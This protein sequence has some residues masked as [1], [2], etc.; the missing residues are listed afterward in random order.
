M[1]FAA[2]STKI[3]TTVSSAVVWRL[4]KPLSKSF[5]IETILEANEKL[6]EMVESKSS[7][8]ASDASGQRSPVKVSE[9]ICHL[10]Q[11]IVTE[12]K[13]AM[14]EAIRS[15]ASGRRASCSVRA[16]SPAGDP[17]SQLGDLSN[18][19]TKEICDKILALYHFLKLHRSGGETTSVMSLKSLLQFQ[20][21]MKGLEKVVSVSRSSSWFTVSTTSDLSQPQPLTVSTMPEVMTPGSAPQSVSPFSEQFMSIASEVVTEILL[22]MEQK[23]AASMSAQTSVSASSETEPNFLMEL[24]KST[25]TEILGKLYGILVRCI[26]QSGP[27]HEQKFLSFAQKIH[28]DIHKR[29]FSF[30]SERKQAVSEKSKTLLDACT[31][32]DAKL[33]VSTENF[34]ESAAA[35]QFLD[36]A[37]QVASDI[38]VKRLTLEIS[39]GLIGTKGSGSSTVPSSMSVSLT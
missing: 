38:L 27:E 24:A 18:A 33:D 10:G 23:L 14:L 17:V 20:K 21:L 31:E 9:F 36:K 8:S 34:Q 6:K 12:I 19:C 25:A 2:A 3:V 7:E 32:T 1:E 16:S 30:I 11:R 28:V 37:T 29:V 35:G 15:T 26:D 4:L 5:G 13:G 39:S 22:K